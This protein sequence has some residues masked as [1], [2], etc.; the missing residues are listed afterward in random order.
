VSPD[1]PAKEDNRHTENRP[2]FIRAEF[3]S[4]A[5]NQVMRR[6]ADPNEFDEFDEELS[7]AELEIATLYR[8]KLAGLRYLSRSERPHAR[9]AMREWYRLALRAIREK[10]AVERHA[11]LNLRQLLTPELR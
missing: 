1:Y 9:R 2:A 5:T 6:A 10:R 8:R 11:R 3:R 7:G 4:A